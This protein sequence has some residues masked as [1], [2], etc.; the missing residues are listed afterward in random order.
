MEKMITFSDLHNITSQYQNPTMK[1]IS[2]LEPIARK[3]NEFE[4]YDELK[5]VNSISKSC[6]NMLKISLYVSEYRLLTEKR[7]TLINNVV[8]FGSYLTQMM[9]AAKL[10]LADSELTLD[11]DI[12]DEK[13]TLYTDES[14]LSKAIFL[15]V[16]RG[17]SDV[18]NGATVSVSLAKRGNNAILTI[19]DESSAD[20]S[21]D[22]HTFLASDGS[23]VSGAEDVMMFPIAAEIIKLLGGSII[24][25]KKA[26][27][28]SVV[29]ISLPLADESAVFTTLG[30]PSRR[31]L[32]NRYS[33]MHIIFSGISNPNFF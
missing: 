1:I 20:C 23:E 28:G 2:M 19:T 30:S 29:T 12:T 33:D 24:A 32:T 3:L 15:L 17:C 26:D 10:L 13:T 8:D 5:L 25:T 27:F 18:P 11:F 31:Y 4:C 7:V 9:N 14:Y 21:L 6:Y 22:I 16:A